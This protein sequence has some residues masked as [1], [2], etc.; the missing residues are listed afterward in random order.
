MSLSTWIQLIRNA[1]CVVKSL[2]PSNASFM[3]IA[4][5]KSAF[6][7][8][9]ITVI[10]L[11]IAVTQYAPVVFLI[12]ASYKSFVAGSRDSHRSK[13]LLIGLDNLS[14]QGGSLGSAEYTILRQA[15]LREKDG[16]VTRQITGFWEFVIGCCFV[17]LG[18]NSLHLRGP[19]HPLPL[20]RALC[21]M[22][23][24]LIYFLFLMLKSILENI[25]LSI[26]INNFT[27]RIDDLLKKLKDEKSPKLPDYSELRL[28]QIASDV[29]YLDNLMEVYKILDVSFPASYHRSISNLEGLREDLGSINAFLANNRSTTKTEKEDKNYVKDDRT[30]ALLS[31]QER[32]QKRKSETKIE[33]IN[34]TILFILNFIAFY[35]YMMSILSFYYPNASTSDDASVMEYFTKIFC[36]NLSLSAADFYGSLAGDIAWALEPAYVLFVIPFL[37]AKTS[38]VKKVR[39]FLVSLFY[40]HFT[41]VLYVGVESNR[42]R[43]DQLKVFK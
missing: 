18:N 31:Y 25:S 39:S 21:F 32:L 9:E 8:N 36:L 13:K 26:K 33:M 27:K 30:N 11:V 40:Y 38:H 10:E 19:T 17:F 1:L 42:Q 28:L 20:I 2:S 35:G 23:V 12:I 4:S 37:K 34:T 7:V 5:P 29:G 24:G 3:Q 15:I 16:G 22:E 41:S 43:E 14:I 6:P